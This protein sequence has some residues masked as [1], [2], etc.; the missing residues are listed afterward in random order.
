MH[1]K[2]FLRSS[3]ATK[4]VSLSHFK[5][6]DIAQ[7]Q[8]LLQAYIL[9]NCVYLLHKQQTKHVKLCFQKYLRQNSACQRGSEF[10]RT[11]LIENKNFL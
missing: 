9:L 10:I 11:A 1:K 6:T 4:I 3:N 8:V 7:I 2:N 5:M